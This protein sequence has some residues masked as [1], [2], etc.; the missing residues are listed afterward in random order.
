MLKFA[1]QSGP[2]VQTHLSSTIDKEELKS[3]WGEN[4][5]ED[6]NRTELSRRCSNECHASL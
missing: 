5:F 1:M 2:K 3:E 4:Y 6:N